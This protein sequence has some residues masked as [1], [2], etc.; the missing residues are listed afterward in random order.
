VVDGDDAVESVVNHRAEPL[1]VLC[2]SLDLL[3]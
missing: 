3:L 2:R 1:H